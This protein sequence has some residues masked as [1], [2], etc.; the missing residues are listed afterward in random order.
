MSSELQ[1]KRVAILATDGFEQAELVQPKKALDEAG[2]KTEII[3]IKSGKIKGWDVD[4]WGQDVSVDL[5]LDNANPSDYDALPLP[6]GVM[7]PDKLRVE[8][9]AVEFAK[10]FF[11]KRRPV[12]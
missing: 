4:D 10:A 3:S 7:N 2:A 9:K 6:G 5:T 12:A 1:G 8:P 11:T